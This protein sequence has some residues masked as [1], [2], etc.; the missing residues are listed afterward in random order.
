MRRDQIAVALVCF[1]VGAALVACFPD[2][3][4][5]D[6][7]TVAEQ[8]SAVA[9]DS[10]TA[11]TE[12]ADAQLTVADTTPE[13]A[14]TGGTADDSATTDVIPDG[15][16]PTCE[17]ACEQ[18]ADPC[19]VSR[20]TD[21]GCVLENAANGKPCDDGALCTVDD[22]CVAGTC[23]GAPR[24]CSDGIDCT[25]DSC[26]EATGCVYDGAQCECGPGV[27]CDDG[28]ACN[29]VETCDLATLSCKAGT[30]IANNVPCNDGL[31][32]TENDRCTGGACVGTAVAC[33]DGVPCTVDACSE[34]AGGCTEDAAACACLGDEDCPDSNL[35]D[36][37]AWCDLEENR[38]ASGQAVACAPTACTTDTCQPATGECLRADKEDGLLCDA[39]QVSRGS[40]V[41][42]ACTAATCSDGWL[43]GR[44]TDVD[45]GGDCFP[46]GEDQLCQVDRDC[47]S[48]DC[49]EGRCAPACGVLGVACPD[50]FACTDLGTC[51]GGLGEVFVPGRYLPLEDPGFWMGCNSALD[52]GCASNESPKRMVELRAYAIDRTEVTAGAYRACVEAGHCALPT[53]TTGDYP[54]YEAVEKREH[55]I[56]A[57]KWQDA[58]DYCAWAGKALCTEA[59][60]ERA[61]RGGCETVAESCPE[62]MRTYPWGEE[63]PTCERT[64]TSGPSDFGCDLDTTFPTGSKPAGRSPYG[65]LDMAGN[66]AEWVHDY[67]GSYTGAARM[68][69]VGPATGTKRVVRGGSF[70]LAFTTTHRDGLL[71]TASEEH[72]GFRCCRSLGP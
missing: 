47:T 25:A 68:D 26:D 46:C 72:I 27:L 59:Q 32:C 10:A 31:I 21:G 62:H 5:V 16:A 48:V 34:A 39:F 24:P 9:T 43:N 50:G 30:P 41:A 15:T 28:E 29:G 55:P 35:C 57:V 7:T 53:A 42:G 58:R 64:V 19:L 37:R 45:C 49:V 33:D 23:L 44:E 4:S 12:D 36:G 2:P 8:D 14:D 71:P 11:S 3:K 69:P 40:C 1:A 22:S 54:T 61:A 63:A 13:P 20:C 65:A 17:P 51:E 67:L 38:C 60:W 70:F 66:V 18:P 56:N 52:D 6:D